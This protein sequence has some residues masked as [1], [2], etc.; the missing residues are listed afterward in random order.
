VTRR[1]LW[2]EYRAQHPDGLKYTAFCVR[3][4][5]WRATVGADVTLALDHEPGDQLFVDYSGDPAHITD[6]STGE[7]RPMQLFVAVWGFS[8][9]LYAEATP[10]QNTED[11]LRATASRLSMA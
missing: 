3:Y 7:R 11:W 1:Q 6:P 10:T 9:Y 8:H 5:R 4:Q 2:R